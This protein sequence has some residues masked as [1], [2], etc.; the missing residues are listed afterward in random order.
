VALDVY[1]DGDSRVWCDSEGQK[2][3][4]LLDENYYKIAGVVGRYYYDLSTKKVPFYEEDILPYFDEAYARDDNL[5]VWMR[6]QGD[7][8]A[9]QQQLHFE[10]SQKLCDPSRIEKSKGLKRNNSRTAA[11]VTC[12]S[13]TTRLDL[14]YTFRVLLNTELRYQEYGPNFWKV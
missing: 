11:V 3:W 4:C 6:A 1:D 7:L 10:A 14:L 5:D 13:R 9:I 8:L 12:F 2:W